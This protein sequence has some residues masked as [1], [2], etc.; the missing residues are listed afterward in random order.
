MPSLMILYGIVE[1]VKKVNAG[2]R[3]IAQLKKE[4]IEAREVY[5]D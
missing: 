1:Q 3:E 4:L 5:T 2:V